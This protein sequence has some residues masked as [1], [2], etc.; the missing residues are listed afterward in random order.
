[1][2][3]CV[4]AV[5]M[6]ADQTAAGR[7]TPSGLPSGI[8][9]LPA[10][11]PSLNVH[12]AEYWRRLHA[13]AGN[14]PI[15]ILALSGGGAGGAFSA[16]ALVGLSRRGERPSY[17][18]VTGVSSGAL[19]APFAY[20]GTDWDPQLT[21]AFASERIERLLRYPAIGMLRH[22]GLYGSKPLIGFVN[23]FYTDALI[24]AVAA[25]SDNGRMLLVATTDIDTEDTVVWDLGAIASLRSGPARNLFR[26]VLVASASLPGLLPPVLIPVEGEGSRYDEMH[27]DG[28]ATTPFF[29]APDLTDTA[30]D[31]LG[32]LRG[33]NVYVLLNRHLTA[34]AQSTRKRTLPILIRS[35]SATL[36]MM[37]RTTLE[38][39]AAFARSHGLNLRVASIPG[40]YPLQSPF[41]FQA[42]VLRALFD[43]AAACAQS[44]QLWVAPEEV[45]D[46]PAPVPPLDV[47]RVAHCPAAQASPAAHR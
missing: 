8:R 32:N 23:H 2:V 1:M 47:S 44:G 26:T 35:L 37:S 45:L 3:G 22:P 14:G 40:D 39:N 34:T 6:P 46:H 30:P 10:D 16:G 42:P 28:G 38:V 4:H 31:T 41:N 5:R 33:V 24:D 12:A 29:V 18:V 17:T 43:F 11:R 25:Q 15:N 20:L 36:R 27:V 19:L 13:A 9:F 21:Q 7:A